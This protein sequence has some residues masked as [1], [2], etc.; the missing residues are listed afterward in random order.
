MP[1]KVIGKKLN[2]GF[3]GQISRQEDAIVTTRKAKGEIPFGS[4]IILNSDN[5]FE[6]LKAA[7]DLA[8]FAGFALREVKQATVYNTGIAKYEDGEPVSNLS[9][10][11]LTVKLSS[12]TPE[13][14][15]KVYVRVVADSGKNIGDIEAAADSNNTVELPGVKFTTGKVDANNV[16]EITLTSRQ[17]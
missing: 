2:Y 7:S 6:T 17:M 4:A 8:K 13:A 14:G 16:V 11:S 5:E 9:R 3:V 1:G 10:G 15:G 12:G